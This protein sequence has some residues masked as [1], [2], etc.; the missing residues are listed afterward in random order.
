MMVN[1][2]TYLDAEF[3]WSK[4][5]SRSRHTKSR[6]LFVLL[7]MS[8][9]L[10]AC[11]NSTTT[12]QP[13]T[14]PTSVVEEAVGPAATVSQNPGTVP[15]TVVIVTRQELQTLEPYQL[16]GMH[17]YDSVAHHL[18]DS[19]VWIDHDL[20]LAPMLAEEW[21]LVND[22][23][24]QFNL[25]RDVIFHN[26]EPF[27]ARAVK[28]SLERA[29]SLPASVETFFAD[30]QVETVEIVDNYAVR[31]RTRVPV[32]NLPYLIANVE[33][34]PP[35]Y[36][37]QTPATGLATQPV[38]TG[39]YRVQSWEPG[40]PLI[41]E[42]NRDYWQGQPQL[43]TLVFDSRE[44]ISD[45][46]AILQDGDP[47][48]VAD[49]T[50]DQAAVAETG[51][52]RFVP[53]ESTSRLFIGIRP[54][55]ET[56]LADKRVR[57]ALNYAVDVNALID[58]FAGGFGKPYGSWV[59]SPGA[60]PDLVPR[61]V[62]LDRARMLLT[63]AGYEQGFNVVLDV[64]SGR[65]YNDL[66][67]AE[68]IREQLAQVGLQVTVQPYDW[69]HYV[70]KRLGPQRTSSLFLLALSSQGDP[71]TDTQNLSFTFPFNPTQWLNADFEELIKKAS[72]TFN[73]QRRLRLLH[74]AQAIAYE[75]APWI[76][77]WRLYD[78]YATTPDLD[79]TPRPDGLIYLYRPIPTDEALQ[80]K[81]S[82]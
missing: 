25:R 33:M 79:W 11:S 53:V 37:S 60:N 3:I 50:S 73:E 54:D 44:D 34:L 17:P 41:L 31:I 13:E 28:F 5:K 10:G 39:P 58:E 81:E 75:E 29:A 18:W 32:S 62:D 38:G 82:Q 57:Q 48:I 78:F 9:M 80:G 26:G 30:A 8:S 23:T 52:T 46:L 42:A 49:L 7:I 2:L 55:P 16:V 67:I 64:P 27:D 71:L 15:Q 19:L 77:L 76:W 65:Y 56:P 72:G 68:A 22:Q 51:K 21:M 1:F 47:T 6:Y 45:R 66:A 4:F 35:K 61:S 12:P 69:E 63:E 20:S 14:S 59:L 36:Y 70:T 24:W 43:P 40:E 74:Q